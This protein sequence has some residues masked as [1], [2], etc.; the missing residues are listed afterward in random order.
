V[1]VK[2]NLLSM[3]NSLAV[4]ASCLRFVGPNEEF[5]PARQRIIFIIMGRPVDRLHGYQATKVLIYP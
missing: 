2:F 3:P 1:I 5:V 4:A